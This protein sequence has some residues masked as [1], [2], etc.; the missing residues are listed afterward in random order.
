MSEI[1]LPDAFKMLMLAK[2]GNEVSA[3]AYNMWSAEN[4]LPL[5]PNDE[6][7]AV[8]TYNDFYNVAYYYIFGN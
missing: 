8:M 7:D 2:A 4:G 5:L 6:Y 1:L 3:T